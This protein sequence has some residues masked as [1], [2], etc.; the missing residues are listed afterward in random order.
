MYTSYNIQD[1][2]KNRDFGS[3]ANRPT[4]LCTYPIAL[5]TH[6]DANHGI[7]VET[8]KEEMSSNL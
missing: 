5:K 8:F 2:I 4:H 6:A 7:I 3:I 1:L